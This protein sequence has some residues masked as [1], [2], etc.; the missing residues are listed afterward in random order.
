M[1]STRDQ[2]KSLLSSDSRYWKDSDHYHGT[3]PSMIR[4]GSDSPTFSVEFFGDEYGQYKDFKTGDGGSLYTLAKLLGITLPQQ[5]P[6]QNTKLVRSLSEYESSHGIEAGWLAKQGW[7]EGK[8][9][10]NGTDRPALFIPAQDGSIQVRFLDHNKPSYIWKSPRNDAPLPFYGTSKAVAIAEESK[11][12][13]LLLVNGAGSV[14]ACQSYKIPAFCVL[15]GENNFTQAHANIVIEKWDKRVVIALDSDTAGHNATNKILPMFG[16]RGLSIDWQGIEHFDAAD[17]ICLWQDQALKEIKTMV[18]NATVL[19]PSRNAHDALKNVIAEIKGERKPTGRYIPQP[20]KLLHKFGGNCEI[21]EPDRLTGVLGLSAHGKTSFWHSL[22]MMLMYNPRRFGFMIDG[23]EFSP[24]SDS[25]RRIQIIERDDSLSYTAVLR[26]NMRMQEES[27]AIPQYAMLGTVMSDEKIEK[28]DN[29][30]KE[31]EDDW[32]G[33]IEYAEEY[34]YIED[35]LE[36]NRRRTIE[37][38]KQGKPMDMWIFDYL[39]LYRLHEESMRGRNDV[40]ANI[41]LE[42]IKKACRDVHVHGV[43]LLQPNKTP[44][45]EQLARNERLKVNDIAYANPNHFNLILGL[46]TLYS[47][48]PFWDS[49]TQTYLRKMGTDG[50]EIIDKMELKNDTYAGVI[51]VLK[52]TFG[53]TGYVN[54]RAD[55]RNLR[56][57]DESWDS[58]DLRMRT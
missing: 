27:E 58:N 31:L 16:D 33:M 5:A 24:E 26:H 8:H 2:V 32:L 21:L 29:R 46:N 13:F 48:K 43:V 45:A 49:P 56:W 44:S 3:A 41:I 17:F 6:A 4:A 38:R 30:Q 11:L 19:L 40:P 35:T 22:V 9:P 14:E 37:L 36:Y 18:Q 51:E 53:S 47:A 34:E 42:K 54:I 28:L 1:A 20:F 55:Y 39:G 52:N 50:K 15:G 7:I 25:L 12:D 23:R 57:C 10:F